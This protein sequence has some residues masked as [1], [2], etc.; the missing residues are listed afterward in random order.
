MKTIKERLAKE[1]RINHSLA[2]LARSAHC[3]ISKLAR[4]FR[5]ETGVSLHA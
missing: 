4:I 2:D 3:S 1:F 5:L